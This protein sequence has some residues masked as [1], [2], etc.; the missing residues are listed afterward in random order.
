MVHEAGHAFHSMLCVNEPL[1]HYRHSPLE[2]AE[3]ASM[4]MELLT[5]P[6]WGG[7]KSFYPGEEDYLRARRKQIE[8]SVSLLPWIATIDAFQFWVYSNPQHTREQRTAAWLGVDD[9]FGHDVDWA[10][11]EP[12]RK[13]LWQRQLHLF[14]VPF[15]YIEYGIAQLGALQLWLRS[16]EEGEKVAIDA[17]MKA[18]SLG[19]SK[20]LPELFRAAGLKFDFGPEIVKRLVDR[21]ERELEKLPE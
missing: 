18:L 10:G 13:T 12:Y 4:S 1:L 11:L 14:G 20:P 19:G 17:Y 6:Y 5:M 8:G 2:F 9:R 16:L 15:Y 21:V 7:P 3:V